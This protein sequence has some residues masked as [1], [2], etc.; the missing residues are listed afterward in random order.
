MFGQMPDDG[1]GIKQPSL[2]NAS[3]HNAW[4]IHRH[5]VHPNRPLAVTHGSEGGRDANI[6]DQSRTSPL[7]T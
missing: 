5:S 1:V 4:R 7:N 6:S 2:I 3:R